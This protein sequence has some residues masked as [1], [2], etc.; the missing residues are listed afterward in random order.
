MSNAATIFL[1]GAALQSKLERL[2]PAAGDHERLAVADAAR[3]G[4]PDNGVGNHVGAAVAD[5]DGDLDFGKKCQPIL[6]AGVAVEVALLAAVALGL[7][8]HAG[9]NAEVGDGPQHRLR[10]KG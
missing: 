3:T 2:R 8:D 5:P 7:P 10:A 1:G 6:T 4:G 9:R